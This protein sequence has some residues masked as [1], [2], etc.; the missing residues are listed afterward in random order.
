MV[1]TENNE[2]VLSNSAK[3]KIQSLWQRYIVAKG[4]FDNY[5]AGIH[6]ALELEDG[7]WQLDMATGNL[8]STA[9]FER[10]EA[11]QSIARARKR[12]SDNIKS[13]V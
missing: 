12:E 4:E 11:E 6:D 10:R 3:Q 2:I 13:D 8:L 5:L 7:K 1:E 9:E